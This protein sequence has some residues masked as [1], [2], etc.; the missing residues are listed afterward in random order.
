[1]CIELNWYSLGWL[2]ERKWPRHDGHDFRRA[3]I[4]R[5]IYV[6]YERGKIFMVAA[7]RRDYPADWCGNN[8]RI[9]KLVFYERAIMFAVRSPYSWY[10]PQPVPVV[11]LVTSECQRVPSAECGARS[12]FTR[13]TAPTAPAAPTAASD[14]AS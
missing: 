8:D 3:K 11:T 6:A 12:A 1:M 9:R 2:P 14:S 7:I 13:L 4:A 5:L 10:S